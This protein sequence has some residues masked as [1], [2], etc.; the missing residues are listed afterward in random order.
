MKNR[1]RLSALLAGISIV[2]LFSCLRDLP[3]ELPSGYEWNPDVAF[4]IG[5]AEFGIPTEIG[6]DSSLLQTDTTGL[7][8]YSSYE[9]IPFSESIEVDFESFL[10]SRDL[11]RYIIL[12]MNIYNGYPSEVYV[13]GYFRNAAGTAVDSLFDAPVLLEPGRL[14]GGGETAEYVLTQRDVLFEQDA[15]DRLYQSET[16]EVAGRVQLVD[17]F[18]QYSFR[19]E[20]SV[21]AGFTYR[22]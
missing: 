7:P 12:R 13:Q 5:E 16:F 11:V 9:Y 20:L 22:F 17:F 18:P 19:I 3:E 8:L 21:H 10:G 6:F 1:I 2:F 14:A 4:P 15:I